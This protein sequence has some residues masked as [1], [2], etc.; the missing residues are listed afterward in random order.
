MFR[1]MRIGKK[2]ILTFV[3][4][5]VLSSCAGVVGLI[6]MRN[7][8][9]N[10]AYA[11]NH[12]GFAQADIGLFHAEFNNSRTI[13]RDIIFETDT[14]TVNT[15]SNELTQINGKV[16][17]CF[18][19]MKKNM[20][21]QNEIRLYNTIKD[22][23]SQ[24]RAI[25][26]QIV[27]LAK[28][29][30]KTEAQTFLKEQGDPLSDKISASID[31]LIQENTSNGKKVSG[32]L[33]TQVNLSYFTMIAIL[34]IALALSF[35]I[36]FTIARGI[37]KP[38]HEM[39]TAAQRMAR[40]DLNV[41]IQVNSK[42]EIGTLGAAMAKSMASIRSYIADITKTLGEI[43]QGNL[44][45]VSQ[46]DYVGDYAELK[47]SC[48]GIL[49][50]LT[51]TLGNI[52]QAAEQVASASEQVSNSSQMLAQGASEQAS[53]VEELAAAVSEISNHVQENTEHAEEARAN[54]NRVCADIEIS[55]RYM[56]EMV[57]SMQQIHNSSGEIGKIIQ[58]IEDIA[59]Q[60]NI[61]AL[62]AAVE[63]ARAGAAGKGF[64]VVADEVRNLAGKSANA[65][66]ET[67]AL[68]QSSMQ[69]V[70]KGTKT[71]DATAKS[72]LQV[73]GSAQTVSN[74]VEHIAQASQKQASAVSQIT[75][76]V[77]QIS[78]VVQTNSAT[79]EESAAASEE[80]SGQAQSLKE[81][82]QKFKLKN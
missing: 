18:S 16:D 74:N 72:L 75:T 6:Q 35:F 15:Y 25:S 30:K 13:I 60:T 65:A 8:D 14:D 57:D 11:L 4:V 59:F 21:S 33:A 69:Q 26:D 70:E 51:D 27:I 66:K 53:S 58:T 78:S 81:L 10:Y 55:N 38:I 43:K 67:T 62:N 61:L 50:S 34:V 46:L 41:E 36:A 22:T 54:A 39:E 79:A 12:Y 49:E 56:D 24:Y 29:N 42:D 76:G 3:F 32:D 37:S 31:S 19:N 80:F 23:L 7:L 9:T 2:L 63:A 82:V 1:N 20:A 64:A 68:I 71:A 52:N 28:Q 17:S 47:A 77:D 73:I 5:T 44:T 48:D 45:A 40:G